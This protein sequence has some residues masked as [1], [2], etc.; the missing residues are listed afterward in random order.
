QALLVYANANKGS[1]PRTRY[2]GRGDGPTSYT[3]AAASNP[4]TPDGPGPNDVT[5]AMFLLVRTTDIDPGAFNCPTARTGIPWDLGG[6]ARDQ[7]SN[8]PGRRYIGYSCANPYPTPA[9]VT[10][11]FKMNDTLTSDFA[12]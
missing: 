8:F 3:G 7:V 4:F 1:F 6:K 10:A 12:L 9:A 5:A 11:G 2:D